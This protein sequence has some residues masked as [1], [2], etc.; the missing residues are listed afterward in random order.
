MMRRIKMLRT[1]T[2]ADGSYPLDTEVYLEATRAAE[3]VKAGM[4]VYIDDPYETASYRQREK[5]VRSPGEKKVK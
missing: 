4:A 3:M 5:A 2:T 1:T